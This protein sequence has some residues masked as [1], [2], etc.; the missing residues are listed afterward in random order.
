MSNPNKAE[1]ELGSSDA[2]RIVKPEEFDSGTAQTPGSKRFSAIPTKL[3]SGSQLWAGLFYVEPKA[4]T[5]IHHH[6]VQETIAYV[7]EGQALISW[8]EHGEFEAIA[9]RGDFIRVPPFLPHREINPSSSVP[10]SWVVVR[11]TSMPILVNLPDD[12]WG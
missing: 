2:I 9:N 6:G 11:S 7:L 3:S 12:Y 5:G 10:F 4:Q 1:N 8:G